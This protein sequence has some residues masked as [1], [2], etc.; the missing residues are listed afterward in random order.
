MNDNSF[1][2]IPICKRAKSDRKEPFESIV[3][4]LETNFPRLNC[5]GRCLCVFCLGTKRDISSGKGSSA[6]ID[7][8]KWKPNQRSD[9]IDLMKTTT[10]C[11]SVVWVGTFHFRV[12]SEP[13]RH[14]QRRSTLKFSLKAEKCTYVWWRLMW[15]GGVPQVRVVWCWTF[16]QYDTELQ[17]E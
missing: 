13:H 11:Y 14:F 6:E 15:W 16:F 17:V 9:S 12:H 10:Q 3:I 2:F 8:S 4:T 5:W 1:A 7:H